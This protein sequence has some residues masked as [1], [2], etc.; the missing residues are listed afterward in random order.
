M[1]YLTNKTLPIFF[2]LSNADL[3][4]SLSKKKSFVANLRSFAKLLLQYFFPKI[5]AFFLDLTI[6]PFW[7]VFTFAYYSE[8][9]I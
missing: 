2:E 4:K 3:L 5:I 6:A 1:Y 8:D 7:L 9:W